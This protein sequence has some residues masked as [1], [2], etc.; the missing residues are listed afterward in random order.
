MIEIIAFLGLLYFAY[1]DHKTQ[2]I[3]N[4]M[5]VLYAVVLFVTQLILGDLRSTVL[6]QYGLSFAISLLLFKLKVMGA[7]DLKIWIGLTPIFTPIDQAYFLLGSMLIFSIYELGKS[8][9]RRLKTADWKFNFGRIIMSRTRQPFAWAFVPNL[10]YYLY[11]V[12]L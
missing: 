8:L 5:V 6:N 11:K 12:A 10:I 3:P 4:Q 7:G 1:S 9:V 2:K